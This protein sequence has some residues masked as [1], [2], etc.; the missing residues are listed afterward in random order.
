MIVTTHIHLYCTC[1]LLWCLLSIFM[2]T[3]SILYNP[4][5]AP[6]NHPVSVVSVSLPPSLL[7]QCLIRLS[8]SVPPSLSVLS[9]LWHLMSLWV[10]PPPITLW[11][12]LYFSVSLFSVIVYQSSLSPSFSHPSLFLP[13]WFCVWPQ[14]WCTLWLFVC[15]LCAYTA[16]EERETPWQ[17]PQCMYPV[18]PVSALSFFFP[19]FLSLSHTLETYFFI[20]CHVMSYHAGASLKFIRT[21][22]LYGMTKS[23]ASPAFKLIPASVA[24]SRSQWIWNWVEVCTSPVI[25]NSD[26]TLS[27]SVSLS[28]SAAAASALLLHVLIPVCSA[29]TMLMSM[30]PICFRVSIHT[31][32]PACKKFVKKCLNGRGVLMCVFMWVCKELWEAEEGVMWERVCEWMC[33]GDSQCCSGEAR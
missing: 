30:Y 19:F 31:C 16:A 12:F 27:H 6:T 21:T 1:I 8:F 29:I 28:L 18:F 32:P 9:P 23:D 25:L 5:L 2:V 10:D 3:L 26:T 22:F 17:Y 13:F 33:C 7:L 4:V 20:I 15:L 11:V 14:L 24:T